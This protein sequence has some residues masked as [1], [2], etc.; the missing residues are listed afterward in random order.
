VSNRPTTYYGW[1]E[2]N[3]R[4]EVPSDEKKK[5]EK[6]NGRVAVDAVSGE[7]FLR[8]SPVARTEELAMY[9]GE[10]CQDSLSQNI[11]KL[12]IILDNNPTHKNK[13]RRHLKSE[14]IIR[15]IEEKIE[16][17]FIYL[18]PYSPDFNLAE[19][20]IHLLRLRLL[21]HVPIGTT[22][23]Q[24]RVRIESFL[25]NHQ[26]QNSIQIKNTI[27]HICNLIL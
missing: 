10:L 15:E 16:I 8:L 2:K 20:I 7:E 23:E 9:F 17:E 6:L 24:A 5:R 22:I 19:Y 3:S 21:H 12:I 14:L 11:K 25:E 27:Q 18:P 13:L 26:L 4:P 1:A